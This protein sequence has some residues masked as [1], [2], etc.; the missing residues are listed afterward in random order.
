MKCRLCG[1]EIVNFEDFV[2]HE[3]V[4]GA[5]FFFHRKC[6]EANTRAAQAGGR[7]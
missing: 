6:L 7:R 5:G 3:F 1:K 4:R 2:Q